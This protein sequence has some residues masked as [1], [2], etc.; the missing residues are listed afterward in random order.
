[1]GY[2][3]PIQAIS[4]SGSLLG[5][6]TIFD[7]GGM[8]TVRILRSTW[9]DDDHRKKALGRL[10]RMRPGGARRALR[11]RYSWYQYAYSCKGA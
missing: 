4:V 10:A 7:Q 8:Q 1:M 3:T 11:P 5:L 9:H 2:I 6:L